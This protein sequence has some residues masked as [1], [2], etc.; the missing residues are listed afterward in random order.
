MIACVHQPNYIPWL[1]FFAKIAQSTVYIVL[2]NVQFPKNCWTNRARV[3][4]SGEAMWL[5]VPV[6]RSGLS[7]L[8]ADV[9]IDYASDW[10]KRQRNTL[11]A[12]YGRCNHFNT[13]YPMFDSILESRPRRLV[14]LNVPLIRWTLEALRI[15]TRVVIS[16]ELGA[17]GTASELLIQ[18]CRA[19]GA[20]TYLAGQGAA[21]YD[22]L[23]AYEDAGVQYRRQVFPHPEYPQHNQAAFVQG[24]SILDALFN[25]GYE[26]TAHLLATTAPNLVESLYTSG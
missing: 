14:D 24:L 9:E 18:L 3:A 15:Q 4:G 2:D 1:G 26:N 22:D 19:V 17:A 23:K 13:V 12:R 25:I 8:I 20:N 5:T 7:T 16:S 6:R 10:V 11:R 21:A